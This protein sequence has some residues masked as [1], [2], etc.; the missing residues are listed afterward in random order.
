VWSSGLEV[1]CTQK[2]RDDQNE[3]KDEKEKNPTPY[4]N[5]ISLEKLGST[6]LYSPSFPPFPPSPPFISRFSF[7]FVDMSRDKDS[8]LRILVLLLPQ[9]RPID[10]SFRAPS[11]TVAIP[12]RAAR[13]TI[14]EFP[15][16]GVQLRELRRRDIGRRG[17]RTRGRAFEGSAEFGFL[18]ERE[19]G[20]GGG[21]MGRGKGRG[22]DV[23]ASRRYGPVGS[24]G[25]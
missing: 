13:L 3:E 12:P 19:D 5:L 10:P 7:S 8:L 6:N 4:H 1:S 20:S 11:R 17:R 24:A 25:N 15:K 22:A 16:E 18:E 9:A 2:K 21:G 23:D 14:P